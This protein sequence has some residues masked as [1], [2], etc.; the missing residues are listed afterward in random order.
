MAKPTPNVE[1]AI[2]PVINLEN[3]PTTTCI[4][5]SGCLPTNSRQR[6]GLRT[7][8]PIRS[9]SF[10]GVPADIVVFD[11]ALTLLTPA[12]FLFSTGVRVVDRSTEGSY[13]NLPRADPSI[14]AELIKVLRQLL[15]S[16]LETKKNYDD[17]Q[18]RLRS[19]L[20]LSTAVKAIFNVMGAS[21]GI[22]HQLGPHVRRPRRDELPYV[23][24]YNW[25]HGGDGARGSLGCVAS[26]FWDEPITIE[27]RGHENDKSSIN[28][29]DLVAAFVSKF[30][31]PRGLGE[32]NIGCDQFGVLAENSW[33]DPCT[34]VNPA[35]LD[36]EKAI[37]ILGMAA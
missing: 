17:L 16:L 2:I 14:N 19:Q 4:I 15:A 10:P 28:P 24:N 13:D 11:L 7:C 26:A 20:A 27:A 33:T 21:H 8:R 29:G 25:T 6:E 12:R 36:R 37:E 18:A 3:Y 30:G 22:G 35:K 1:P 31:L 5:Q 9:Q 23:M 32:F 34:M